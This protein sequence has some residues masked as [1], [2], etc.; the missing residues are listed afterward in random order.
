M[1]VNYMNKEI[2]KVIPECLEKIGKIDPDRLRDIGKVIRYALPFSVLGGTVYCIYKEI[3]TDKQYEHEEIMLQMEMEHEER[4]F[5]IE[6]EE[7]TLQMK[8]SHE[9]KM[10]EIKANL[11][12]KA[13]ER[14]NEKDI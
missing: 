9:E 3:M 12:S 8:Y 2:I 10:T 6:H 7:V 4:M 1:G 13:E 14:K 11:L 5:Q